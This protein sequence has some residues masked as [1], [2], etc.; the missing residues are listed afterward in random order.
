LAPAARERRK[1]VTVIFADVV[2]STAL[3]ERVDPETLRW[4]MQRW[5]GRMGD[6]IER[7]GGTVENFIGDAVMGVFGIPVVHEDDALRAVRAAAEMRDEVAALRGEL[8]R[9]RGVELA[10]RIG[11][12]T[13]E[14][15]TGATA[16][17][18]S[19]TAGD[20][21][22]VAARLEQAARPGDILLGHDTFRLVRHA[23]DAP[24]VPSLTV[25]GKRAPLEAF[26]LVS[27]AP[28]A[29][30]RPQRPR[31]PMVGRRRER[32]RVLDAFHQAVA[33]RSCQL[34]TVLGT[35]G[36]GKSRLVAEV[37][38]TIDGAATVAAGRCLPYGDGL[39]WWPLAEALGGPGLLELAAA[40]AEDAAA[41][42]SDLLA[43]AGAPVAPEE[44]RWA[45]RKV[46]EAL[47]RT[48][49]LVLVVD[50]LQWAE[51]TFVDVLE[52]VA[53][54]SRDVPLLLLIM[55]RP[56]LLDARPGWGGGKPN[57][58]SVL[59]E[60]L[61]E[62]E[63]ADLLRHLLGT[64]R[65]GERAAAQ[66]LDVAEGNPLYVEEIV[67]MLADEGLLGAPDG[68]LPIAVPPTIHALLAARLDRLD[69]GQR[70]VI[71]AAAI[72]GKE[73]AREGVEALVGDEMRDRVGAHLLALVR[74]DLIR[75]AGAGE[76]AFRFRH[77]LIRDA[78]YDGISKDTRAVLHERF[79]DRLEDH[80]S[81][82]ASVDELL[83]HHLERAVLLRRELGAGEAATAGLAA[84]ASASLL[85]A[86]RRAAARGEAAA[87][88]RML[89]RAL[90]L[91]SDAERPTV[92]VEL[93]GALQDEGEL[94]RAAATAREA[95]RLARVAGDRRTATRAR[96]AELSVTMG[97][98]ETGV[99]IA[100]F[101]AAVKP[102]IDELE[103]LDDDEGLAAG[104]R[105]MAY[106][107]MEC[108]A[109]A[110]AYLERAIVHAERAGNRLD[111]VRAAGTL[112]F[113]ALFGPVPAAEAIERCRALREGVAGHH[114]TE[115]ALL[116]FEAVLL[117]MQGDIDEARAL[118]AKADD[119][120]EDL[121]IGWLSANTVFTR[122]SLELLAGAPAR[123]ERAARAGLE[124]F[125]AM[126]NRN[127]GSTA[128]ALL[129]L[130]LVEQGRDDEALQ[131][132][133]LAAAWAA[134]DD[135]ASQTR[136]LAVRA[137]VL[138]RRGELAAGEAAA[139]AAVA[140]SKASDD[141]SQRGDALVNLAF[142]LER[143]G[144]TDEAA[145]ALRDALALYQRKGNLVGAARAR[146]LSESEP[147][148]AS[149]TD[150]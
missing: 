5:F 39:T 56:E 94:V 22:N 99:D 18:G 122:T 52:H 130:T 150:T 138:A 25:K 117:A 98:T 81:S 146:A 135:T 29:Q 72:E 91:A 7:H 88:A 4:A 14:A 110:T 104:L 21:V 62:A 60:P 36:V 49:P 133:D 65:L 2:G 68:D 147:G 83:G 145:D 37:L 17:G 85:R 48:R 57:A 100:A 77:Q 12:N 1:V 87:A 123:A 143:A 142:V 6:A 31:A 149:V 54:L 43:P 82:L 132:A 64:A 67:T 134:S 79:A 78:A 27:V 105:L 102:L 46:L 92:L 61:A 35:A 76:G 115:A 34:F 128:A 106:I 66:I 107:T 73:F 20:I 93:A 116:Q 59:L 90:P 16:T 30:G 33:D 42:V 139:R 9:E 51:P 70:A 8:R 23:V 84:R 121:G 97:H 28:D 89:E 44:A 45:V 26:R 108:Y 118:H 95:V 131:Y 119:I 120:I 113:L 11:V 38:E 55:A 74:M 71:E 10:V 63:A 41:R 53:D 75:P 141:L 80:R 32:R 101:E 86:G 50:D 109:D 15:V 40:D 58:T 140:Q 114:G 124:A 19:F 137:R 136:Q 112:G 103:L 96:L 129:G 24:P 13:G 3:G 69:D 144:R 148:R 126:H 127:Q 125:E 111:A 47:G